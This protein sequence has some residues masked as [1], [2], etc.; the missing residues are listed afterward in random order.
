MCFLTRCKRLLGVSVCEDEVF[1][2]LAARVEMRTGLSVR[3]SL[4]GDVAVVW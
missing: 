3:D 4:I 1:I 2:Y